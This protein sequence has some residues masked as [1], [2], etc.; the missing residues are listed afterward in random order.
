MPHDPNDRRNPRWK[1]LAVAALGLAWTVA[2]L[3]PIPH[4][5]AS[6]VLGGDDAKFW[7]AKGLHMG[8]YAFLAFSV[9][10]F[11]LTRRERI[12]VLV[13]LFAH[14]ASTEFFQQF[15]ERGA[16]LRDVMIDSTGIV[17]G[18][19]AGWHWWREIRR[20]SPATEPKT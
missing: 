4:R 17:L 7:F 11:R 14:G 15:V 1:V 10:T 18:V 6:A 20:P 16:S 5:T 9:G 19:A 2:L 13:C 3:I 12:L 8:A